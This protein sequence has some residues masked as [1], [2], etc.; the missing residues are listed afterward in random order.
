MAGFE[1]ALWDGTELTFDE[2]TCYAL[3]DDVSV[4]STA[5]P[6]PRPRRAGPAPQLTRGEWHVTDL[7]AKGMSTNDIAA[8]LGIVQ[9][10]A[11]AHVQHI[12]TKLGF[13]SRAR[14]AAWVVEQTRHA[15]HRAGANFVTWV[16][17]S[18][19]PSGQCMSEAATRSYSA[20]SCTA[21]GDVRRNCAS[22]AAR[23]RSTVGTFSTAAI[24]HRQ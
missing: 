14:L 1:A 23:S 6:A 17:A 11:E 24:Q 16:G 2:A 10:T 3:S 7:V 19:T 15:G 20:Q 13:T 5:Q 4:A 8:S 18:W 21:S 22:A 9:R 12:L